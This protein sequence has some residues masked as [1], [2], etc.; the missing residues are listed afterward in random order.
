MIVGEDRLAAFLIALLLS[1]YG[2]GVWAQTAEP[3]IE[4][5][6][7]VQVTAARIAPLPRAVPLPLPELSTAVSLPADP[8]WKRGAPMTRNLPGDRHPPLLDNTAASDSIRT[9]VRYLE[10]I[11]PPY[12]RRARVMGWEGTVILRVSVGA[13]GTVADVA[14]HKTSGHPLLDQAA[15]NAARDK[16]FT[17]ERDGGFTRSSIAEV[18]VR[19][20]LTEYAEDEPAR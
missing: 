19:F 12:P 6:D 18:P 10:P 14:V 8:F 11:R 16:R 1:V 7:E 15:I 20:V 5:L 4:Q 2:E 17:P 13:D 3:D 9:R